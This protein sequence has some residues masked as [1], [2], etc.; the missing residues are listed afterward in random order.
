MRTA[1]APRRILRS[2][3]RPGPA[4]PPVGPVLVGVT[5][6]TARGHGRAAAVALAGLRLRRTWPTTRG[7]V[8]MWLWADPLH[9]RSGS[10]SVWVDERALKEFLR[11][12]DHVRVMRRHGGHGELRSARRE[13]EEFAPESVWAYALDLI[14]EE[15]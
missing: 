3:W 8:G 12:P 10:V 5:D 13:F 14:T 4:L 6:F 15:R 2:P 1:H 7:A 11:R 9:R